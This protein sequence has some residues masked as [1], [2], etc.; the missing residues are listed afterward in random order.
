[1]AAAPQGAATEAD[2]APRAED[3]AAIPQEEDAE[4]LLLDLAVDVINKRKECHSLK[5]EARFLFWIKAHN[6]PQYETSP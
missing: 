3:A 6:F 4:A 2:R 5:I 1:M